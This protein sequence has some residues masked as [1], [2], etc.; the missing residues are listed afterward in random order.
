ME[1]HVHSSISDV[2]SRYMCMYVEYFYLNNQMDRAE[3]IMIKI[4]MIP[5]EFVE[6][7]NIKEE[8]TMGTSVYV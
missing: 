8:R 2:K 1:L 7:Y 4:S 5:Q 3:Y 6:R